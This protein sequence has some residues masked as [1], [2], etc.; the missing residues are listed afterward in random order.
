MFVEKDCLELLLLFY[1]FILIFVWGISFLEVCVTHDVLRYQLFAL[2][3]TADHMDT[4]SSVVSNWFEDPKILTS[5]LE[6][7]TVVRLAT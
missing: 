5:E 1:L 7:S 3:D 2:L 4:L 6:F